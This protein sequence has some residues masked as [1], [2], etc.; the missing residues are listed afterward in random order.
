MKTNYSILLILLLSLSFAGFSQTAKEYFDNGYS[1]TGQDNIGAIADYSKAITLSP[2]YADLYNLRGQ[3]RSA[4]KDPTGAIA[5]Y[6]KALK[7]DPQCAEVYYNRG[8]A[9]G[10]LKDYTGEVAD[11]NK[12]I[13]I[14]PKYADAYMLRGFAKLRLKQKEGACLDFSKA[15]ELG[16]EGAYD[17]IKQFCK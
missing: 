13:S 3:V 2:D 17:A 5:D 1:K 12:A 4:L 14:D 10:N 9:K 7:I 11:Y 6:N 15:G 16:K 8:Y